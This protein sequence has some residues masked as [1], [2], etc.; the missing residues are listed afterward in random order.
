M[1]RFAAALVGTLVLGTTAAHASVEIGGFAGLHIFSSTNGLGV[2]DASVNPMRAAT[3]LKNSAIF[4]ARIGV[5]FSDRLGVEVEA[6]AIPTEPSTTV[7]DVFD[8]V[9][10]AQLVYKFVP[11]EK[12]FVPFA[13]IGG[14][15][16]HVAYTVN[17]DIIRKETDW[18]PHVGV[19]VAYKTGGGWAVRADARLLLPPS[20]QGGITE[21]YEVLLSLSREFG[22]KRPAPEVVE[23]VKPKTADVDSDGDGIPDSK[24]KCP[25]EAEDKDGFQDEDGCPDP[26][27]DG[28][29]IPD[30]KDKCP[31]EAEDK[32]NFQDDDGCPDPDNDGDGIPDAADKCPDQPETKN[33]FQDEDGC[34]DEIPEKLK[35]FT[36]TIQ[37][38]NFKTGEADLTPQLSA[39]LDKA[40]A[41]LGEF[42]E[43]RLEIQGHT[44]DVPLTS[45][46]FAD[47]QAL[48]QA[49]AESVKA[50]FVKKGIDQGRIEAKGFG[51]TVPVEAPAGLTGG[52]LNAARAKN[53]RVEFKLIPSGAASVATPPAATPAP[54]PAT[55]PA[56]PAPAPAK[57]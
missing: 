16:M 31:N 54:A 40:V 5:F 56:A 45:K 47:N 46:K 42:K 44:D 13:V 15:F 41:V 22:G 25:K 18:M 35:A 17:S 49:R 24:D 36:G 7:F 27:N 29:G 50:Y 28:D 53:R 3:S 30:A 6:G 52:K 23:E 21:D 8:I 4:A 39:T 26:D 48:S 20:S 37:G 1:T 10:R 51:D 19:G 57:K 55:P 43:I 11:P 38:I 32:D 2:P 34:P 9:G 12:P 33:G 14:G